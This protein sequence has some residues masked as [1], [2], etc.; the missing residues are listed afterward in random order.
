MDILF[1]TFLG[2]FIAFM[3]FDESRICEIRKLI[4]E[5]NIIKPFREFLSR[6]DDKIIGLFTHEKEER[7]FQSGEMKAM[8]ANLDKPIKMNW[9]N[10]VEFEKSLKA[11]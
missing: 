10:A 1:P 2:A 7:G 8:L 11:K 5:Y 6:C 4:L 3:Y 9:F